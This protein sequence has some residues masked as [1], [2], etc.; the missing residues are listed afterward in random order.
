MQALYLT[1]NFDCGKDIKL[2]I[3]ER[4]KPTV[5]Q[6]E[7]L[8][9][10][11]SSGVNPSDVGGVLGFFSHA[12]L[13][14]IP[15]RDFA[16][17]IVEGDPKLVGKRVWGSGGAAGLYFDG[18]QAEYVSIPKTAVA[19]IPANLDLLT[20]GAQTLP[21]IAAYYSL[22]VRA[23]I[24]RGESVLILG[25]VGQVGSAAMTICEW[26][27]CR[28]I[29]LVLGSEEL[30]RAKE[31]G[32]KALDTRSTHLTEQILALNGG[33]LIDVILNS[34]GNVLWTQYMHVLN[35]FGR[36]VTISARENMRE[37]IV[38]LFDL[39]RCNQELIG[40]N[41][42]AL[43]YTHNAIILNQLKPGFESGALD[44]LKMDKEMVF[45]LQKASDAYQLVMSG[46]SIKRVAL[47]MAEE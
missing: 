16:G 33:M 43:D 46:K 27:G 40:I 10:V 20:A 13:P 39:Y 17:V 11:Y 9:K 37:V 44:P 22:A 30:E 19:E 5:S 18:T 23:R 29:A 3:S 47:T 24:K 42:V 36:I 35:T 7:C 38:N 28:P 15:G 8:V 6:D 4:P 12:K 26:M 45:P 14:R 25:A 1:Y 21:F 34:V 32:W 41:T 2:P 31:L